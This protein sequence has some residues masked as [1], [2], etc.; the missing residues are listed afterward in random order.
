MFL[1]QVKNAFRSLRR[2]PILSALLIGGIGLG[3]AV[4]TAFITTYYVL[5][6]DPIPHKSDRLFY[7]EMDSWSLD[8]PWN[9]DKPEL[10]PNQTNTNNTV[11]LALRL[12]RKIENESSIDTETVKEFMT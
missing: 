3:I 8:K 2:N 11:A 12:H 5:A 1:Y 7:V 4:S 6:G 10:P 9:N